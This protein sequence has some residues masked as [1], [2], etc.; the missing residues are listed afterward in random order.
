M[1]TTQTVYIF[2]LFLWSKGYFYMSVNHLIIPRH[3]A[4]KDCD[5]GSLFGDEVESE[6]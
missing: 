2:A 4:R 3:I 5:F 1:L 6:V